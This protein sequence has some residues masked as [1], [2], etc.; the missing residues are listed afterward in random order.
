MKE[1]IPFKKD[2]LFKT[3]INEI[4]NISLEHDYK[5]MDNMIEGEFI[6]SGAYKM[7]EASVINEDFFYQ[8]PFS[9]AIN[10]N[11]KKETIDLTI[12]DFTYEIENSDILKIN[13]SLMLNCEIEEDKEEVIEK[14]EEEEVMDIIEEVEEE[15]GEVDIENSDR[16]E[17]VDLEEI[18][19]DTDKEVV[20]KKS[21]E[22][23]KLEEKEI[24]SI[25]ENIEEKNDYVTYKVYL[26]TEEDSFESISVKY[27]IDESLLREYNE[28]NINAG[29][30]IIIPFV[31]DDK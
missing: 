15:S 4:T 8:V 22:K 7:T 10:D 3:R 18:D 19:I 24:N 13:I 9:I 20:V 27:D 16:E 12:K 21:D 23:E 14:T 29:D 6:L 17:E 25:I 5:I 1:I 28:E 26:A 2:I 30:K 11:V 31:F